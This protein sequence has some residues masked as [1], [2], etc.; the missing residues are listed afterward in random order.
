MGCLGIPRPAS[1]TCREKME[2]SNVSLEMQLE[3]W[4]LIQES[5]L[6]QLRMLQPRLLSLPRFVLPASPDRGL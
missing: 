6:Y 1:R 3:P 4:Y 5:D 2:K